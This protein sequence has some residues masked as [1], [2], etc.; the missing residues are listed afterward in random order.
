MSHPARWHV[1]TGCALGLSEAQ[2]RDRS[3]EDC[4]S[5]LETVLEVFPREADPVD[6]EPGYAVRSLLMAL[7]KRLAEH[8][9]AGR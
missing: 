3:V 6:D 9:E 1:M 5:C 7:R 8:A 4:L 2:R